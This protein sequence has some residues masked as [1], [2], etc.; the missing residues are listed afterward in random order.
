M[1]RIWA[2]I[3]IS[4]A[5][6]LGALAIIFFGTAFF[7]HV[8]GDEFAP[9]TFARR[10]YSY[11]ELPILHIQVTPVRHVSGPP[12]FTGPSLRKTLLASKMIATKSPPSRWDL[13]VSYRHHDVWRTGDALIL[14][15]YLDATDSED[16]L[17]W[18]KWTRDNGPLAKKLWPEVAKLA[19]QELYILIPD[20]FE[21]GATAKEPAALQ[22]DLNRVLARNYERL[23]EIQARLENH[24]TA[25]R[26]FTEALGYAP[27]RPRSLAGRAR[28]YE[29]VGKRAL[30][31]RDRQQLAQIQVEDSHTP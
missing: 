22:R 9:D 27:G 26:F 8:E 21:L 4:F 28:S 2:W 24:S 5:T 14:C 10:Q 12:G 16:H 11:F 31:A 19:R 3:G 20:L 30:A 15:R 7:G 17:Y 6:L 25:I 1:K 18:E 23:A 29:A 13:A